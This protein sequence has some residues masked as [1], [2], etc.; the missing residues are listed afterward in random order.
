MISI[1]IPTYNE[2]TCIEKTLVQL[3]G[4]KCRVDKEIIVSDGGSTDG[5][6]ALAA[7][8]AKVVRS[9]KGKAIQLNNGA[10]NAKGDI[11]F[12]VHADMFVPDGAL[13]EIC[14]RIDKGYDGGG[15]LNIFSSHNEKIKCLGRIMNFRIRKGEQPDKLIFYGDNGIFVRKKVFDEMGGFKEIPIMEDYDFSYRMRKDYKVA[16]IEEPKIIVDSRRHIKAGFFK[17][18]MQWIIIRKL[19]K[20]GVS[21]FALAKWYAD[22]R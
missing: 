1:I 21:P 2:E 5:T 16:K 4:I 10:K 8:S 19:Y 7:R 17:T 22:V 15:F 18:R 12:F 11:L 20:I 9:E 13:T 6:V 3:S 14:N